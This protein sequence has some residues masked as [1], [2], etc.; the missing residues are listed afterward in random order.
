M[1][2]NRK[3]LK[4]S[5]W[6]A[7]LLLIFTGY[8][9][10]MSLSEQ[11]TLLEAF[12]YNFD[13]KILHLEASR[14]SINTESMSIKRL[15]YVQMQTGLSVIPFDTTSISKRIITSGNRREVATLNSISISQHLPGGGTADG[16]LAYYKLFID[17]KI[18]SSLEFKDLLLSVSQPL[19]RNAWRSDPVAREIA[20]SRIDNNKFSL[21]QKQQLFAYCSDIRNRYWQLFEAQALVMLYRQE[22]VYTWEYM[23]IERLRTRLGHVP[24]HDTLTAQLAY[25]IATVRLHDAE[26][27]VIQLQEEFTFKCALENEPFTL[28]STLS[29][30]TSELPPPD[31]LIAHVKQLDPL[32]RIFILAEDKLKLLNEQLQNSL[33]PN[34]DLKVTWHRTATSD[35]LSDVTQVNRNTVIGLIA[36]YNQHGKSKKLALRDNIIATDKQT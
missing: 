17:W 1:S 23:S 30:V 10:A 4:H 35:V 12:K 33:F 29:I 3:T 32:M 20:I 14:D 5:R 24:P 28:D 36:L 13:I 16:G 2:R 22:A 6:L 8:E 25:T 21:E 11:H 27:Q 7:F 26:S 19:L 9:C 34:V 15:P 31:T 18:D